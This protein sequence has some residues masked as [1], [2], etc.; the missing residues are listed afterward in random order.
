MS[1]ENTV[2]VEQEKIKKGNPIRII[3][4]IL[5]LDLLAAGLTFCIMA[6]CLLLP[7]SLSGGEQL[8]LQILIPLLC[9]VISLYQFARWGQWSWKFLA[10][11]GYFI[12]PLFLKIYGDNRK[13]YVN[14]FVALPLFL[15]GVMIAFSGGFLAGMVI[16]HRLVPAG[17]FLI[18]CS[19]LALRVRRCP[20]CKR[21]LTDLDKDGPM[22]ECY[23]TEKRRANVGTVTDGEHS[24]DVYVDY[25]K[26]YHAYE[27]SLK[28]TGK[29]KVCGTVWQGF[30]KWK[31]SYSEKHGY[32]R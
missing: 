5:Y 30:A 24:A 15:A 27:D 4:G 28:V 21:V 14:L 7:D 13:L 32:L 23:K 6:V 9:V 3:F 10:Y 29:C 2:K 31:E 26:H 16:L 17:L 1:E 20:K 12:K 25:D 19:Y 22:R 18:F 8:F 11:V